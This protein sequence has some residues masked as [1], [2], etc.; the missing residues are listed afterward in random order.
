M[1][2]FVAR[3]DPNP[4]N[5]GS[6]QGVT[7]AGSSS[8]DGFEMELTVLPAEGW[9]INFTPSLADGGFDQ[10][11]DF[12][13]D[14]VLGVVPL[15]RSDEDLP[16][17]PES[18]YSLAV[19]YAWAVGNGKMTARV[20]AYFRDEI[21]WGFDAATWDLDIARENSTTDSYTLFNARLNWQL[22]DSLSIAAWGKNL[23]DEV[24]YDGGV[25]ETANIGHVIKAFSPPRRYGVDVRF[26]F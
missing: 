19:Q 12:T 8:I 7:N 16:S 6:L 14:P 26:D 5:I 10:F 18:S 15:D 11:D 9:L 23:G 17:L 20:D 3:P 4:A 2:L 1:Q 13:N 21:Y 24:Y 22:N 25:G